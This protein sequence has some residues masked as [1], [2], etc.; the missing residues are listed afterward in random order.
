[1]QDIRVDLSDEP[2]QVGIL[3][4]SRRKPLSVRGGR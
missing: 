1:M 3:T 2:P 4:A